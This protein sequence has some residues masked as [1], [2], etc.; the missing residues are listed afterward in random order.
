MG[1]RKSRVG[2]FAV[3]GGLLIIGCTAHPSESPPHQD[4]RLIQSGSGLSVSASSRRLTDNS[5]AITVELVASTTFSGVEVILTPDYA[6]LSVA[7]A[8]CNFPVLKP[9]V[10]EHVSH[11]P[12]PMPVI[13][14]CTFIVS[15]R[16][17]GNY[18]VTIEV[19]DVLGKQLLP[20]LRGI[21]SV[22]GAAP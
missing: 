12:Y 5:A 14:L 13:P 18:F 2:Y 10:V 1:K 7:P 8:E 21:V 19:K 17:A 6:A 16:S 11:P 3:V 22:K 9:P 4:F 20:P 15:A